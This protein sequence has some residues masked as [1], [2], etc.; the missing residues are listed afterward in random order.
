MHTVVLG[1]DV[2]VASTILTPF[3]YIK[4]NFGTD[5]DSLSCTAQTICRPFTS[6]H[7][8]ELMYRC[9]RYIYGTCYVIVQDVYGSDSKTKKE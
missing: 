7:R 5:V 8:L 1:R 9:P 4:H 3:L 6:I 2:N